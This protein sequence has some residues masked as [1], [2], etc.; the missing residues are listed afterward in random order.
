VASGRER[1][2]LFCWTQS[3]AP[4]SACLGR[5]LLLSKPKGVGLAEVEAGLRPSFEPLSGVVCWVMSSR[6]REVNRLAVGSGGYI[7]ITL[8][9]RMGDLDVAEVAGRL[10]G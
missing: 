2:S 3:E 7:A 6:Q 5:V 4:P 9:C 8:E 10:A 1:E